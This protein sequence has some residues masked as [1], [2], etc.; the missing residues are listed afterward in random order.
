[1]KA[2]IAVMKEQFVTVDY[3]QAGPP[4][5]VHGMRMPYL[6]RDGVPVFFLDTQ[7]VQ[8]EFEFVDRLIDAPPGMIGSAFMTT[9][10][11]VIDADGNAQLLP[12]TV[13]PM[14]TV[15]Q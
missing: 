13:V 5:V 8:V 12:L 14:R 6:T 11:Y 9:D 4:S 10:V 3:S 2:S 1:M 15:V 7:E